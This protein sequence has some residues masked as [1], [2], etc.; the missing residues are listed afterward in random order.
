MDFAHG[1]WAEPVDGAAG[2]SPFS[3]VA[4]EPLAVG[5]D[6]E[7]EHQCFDEGEKAPSILFLKLFFN[8]WML[9]IKLCTRS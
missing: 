3:T 4:P 1:G 6:W 9:K 8:E 5:H 2:D 7:Q